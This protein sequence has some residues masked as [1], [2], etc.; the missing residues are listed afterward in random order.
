MHLEDGKQCRVVVS[1][2]VSRADI[3]GRIGVEDDDGWD[4]SIDVESPE[5]EGKRRQ[6]QREE[7][8]KPLERM[9]LTTDASDRTP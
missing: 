1:R 3:E 8:T 9:K 7:T 4:S 5:N 2:E 6:D